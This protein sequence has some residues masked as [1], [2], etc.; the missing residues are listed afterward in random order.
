MSDGVHDGLMKAHAIAVAAAFERDHEA[1]RLYEAG[2]SHDGAVCKMQG[3][4][5]ACIANDILAFA[6][7]RSK[8]AQRMGK[9]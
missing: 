6:Q 2:R 3:A 9:G 1:D 7:A 4:T 8:Q 5:A